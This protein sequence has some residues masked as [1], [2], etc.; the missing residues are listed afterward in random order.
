[1]ELE[2]IL[3]SQKINYLNIDKDK[4]LCCLESIDISSISKERE[5]TL[6]AIEQ[7]VLNIR[8]KYEQTLQR[9]ILYATDARLNF[10]FTV[11]R[12]NNEYIL[13]EYSYNNPFC[14][15]VVSVFVAKT[16]MFTYSPDNKA[17]CFVNYG[18]FESATQQFKLIS[19]LM[20]KLFTNT[21]IQ[22]HR[23]LKK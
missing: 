10:V 21:T 22:E 7:F 19:E 3:G 6:K 14:F 9:K 18:E 16:H 8:Q 1:M 23:L 20:F 2:D 17:L 13:V 15:Y 4:G 12:S 11:I 5:P